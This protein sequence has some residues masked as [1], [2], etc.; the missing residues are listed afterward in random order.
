MAQTITNTFLTT[1][2]GGLLGLG[3]FFVL[4]LNVRWAVGYV[5]SLPLSLFVLTM[6][7]QPPVPFIWYT[8]MALLLSVGAIRRLS[9]T[10]LGRGRM[11][12][13]N[14]LRALVPLFTHYTLVCGLLVLMEGIIVGA[15]HVYFYPVSS[16]DL[17]QVIHEFLNFRLAYPVLIVVPGVLAGL[18]VVA[19]ELLWC[20]LRQSSSP[21]KIMPV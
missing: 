18:F 1:I 12:L 10:E 20:G 2:I 17:G 8:S 7:L 15:P 9:N 6:L 5:L 13:Y 11:A 3:G 4:R 21:Q 14:W 19:F 16:M